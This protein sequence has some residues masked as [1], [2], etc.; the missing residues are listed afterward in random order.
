MSDATSDPVTQFLNKQ[1]IQTKV[2]YFERSAFILGS[3]VVS[4]D[5]EL[6]YRLEKDQLI[7]CHF[8]ARQGPQ[9]LDSAV[10]HFI[11]LIHQIQRGVPEVKSVRGMFIETLSQPEVNETR[12]RLAQTLEAQGAHWETIEGERWLV[13]PMH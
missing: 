7:I 2:A 8:A 6:I 10:R 4:E 9:S 5:I 13:Y 3:E 12:R 11:K 1:G